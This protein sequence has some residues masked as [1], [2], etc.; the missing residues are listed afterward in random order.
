MK[1]NI[2]IAITFFLLG[3]SFAVGAAYLYNAKDIEFIPSDESWNVDNIQSAINDIK[4]NYYSSEDFNNLIKNIQPWDYSYTGSYQTFEVPVTGLYKIEAWGAQ[5]G[6]GYLYTQPTPGKGAYTSGNIKLEVGEKIY[7][8]VG[9]AGTSSVNA[10]S[11]SAAGWN[12]GG[13]GSKSTDGDDSAGAGGGATDIRL[14]S[15][16][17]NNQES[18]ASRIMVAGGGGGTHS[19]ATSGTGETNG[20]Y[21]GALE[22]VGK[23]STWNSV[24]TPIVNQTQGYQF[25][26]GMD[27]P[28]TVHAGAGA[29]GGYYGGY[30]QIVSNASGRASGGSSYISG[31]I[32]CVAI[33]SA[34]DITPLTGCLTGNDNLDCSKHY[35]GKIFENTNMSSGLESMPTHDGT[36]TMTGNSGNGYAKITLVSLD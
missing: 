24:F 30:T 17:W 18:L 11:I 5:G 3:L 1:K 13:K 21:A 23:I 12:G 19:C 27:G 26:I 32:G 9:G 22:V 2:I 34:T 4:D 7:I 20:M 36:S 29:G 16:E 14:V 31:H 10:S 15:G 28:T 35:S 25:G 8:Y 6:K 33:T